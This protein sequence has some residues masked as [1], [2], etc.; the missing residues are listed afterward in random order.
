MLQRRETLKTYEYQPLPPNHIRIINLQPGDFNDS[1]VVEISSERPEGLSNGGNADDDERSDGY[2]ALSWQWGPEA[3]TKQIRIKNIGDDMHRTMPVRPNLL[4]A[5]KRLRRPGRVVRLWVDA[6]CIDQIELGD[7]SDE[8]KKK[9]LEKSKQISMMTEIFGGADEVSV[10]LGE[11]KDEEEKTE[12]AL[13]VG[14]I[15]KL[16]NLDDTDH[17]AGLDRKADV[18]G[19]APQLGPFVRLLKRGW[20]SRRWVVQV[21][22]PSC[23]ERSEQCG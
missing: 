18:W 17:I 4:A 20:F 22:F 8:A 21:S 13:A 11:P 9:N 1:V 6:I 2:N 7:G 3:A 15:E 19:D 14:F 10:W 12:T 16:V 23:L 5:L